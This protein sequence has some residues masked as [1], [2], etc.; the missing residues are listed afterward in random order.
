M[1]LER[2]ANQE[3]FNSA[4]LMNAKT[5]I[6]V[7]GHHRSGTSLRHRLIKHHPRVSGFSN[8]GAP[9]DEG[10]HLQSLYLPA[11]RLGGPGRYI[12]NKNAYMNENHALATPANA[13]KLLSEWGK[14]WDTTVDYLLEKSPPNLIRL[15]F[16]QKLFPSSKLVVVLRHPVAVA[17]ATQK[18]A[19]TSIT[20]LIDH[21]LRGM[22][23]LRMTCLIYGTY[24]FYVMR[25]LS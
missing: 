4:F 2:L 9:E 21:T 1:R 8:T 24:M 3:L 16:L 11:I 25:T 15:R 7:A 14:Y 17:Y 10:Q 22:R 19:K 5:I 23:F 18:W 12:F 6:F 13:A 20:S